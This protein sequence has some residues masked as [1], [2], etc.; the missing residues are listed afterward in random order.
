VH[1]EEIM[2]AGVVT[3]GV[4]GEVVDEGGAEGGVRE[5]R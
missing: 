5:A 3:E 2:V 4:V 1:Q